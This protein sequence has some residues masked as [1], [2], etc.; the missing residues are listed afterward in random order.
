MVNEVLADM[1]YES[2]KT[3][4]DQKRGN[5]KQMFYRL[6]LAPKEVDFPAL[7]EQTE[8]LRS[9]AET[10]KYSADKLIG[11]TLEKL[12]MMFYDNI[13]YCICATS[14]EQGK[15]VR[16]LQTQTTEYT[17]K[18]EGGQKEKGLQ[19]FFASMSQKSNKG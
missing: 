5:P 4:A 19:S 11:E 7:A 6:Q 14:S 1:L 12:E 16:V 8:Q 9:Q 15:L 17:G 13:I 10:A 18:W 3:Y 2:S